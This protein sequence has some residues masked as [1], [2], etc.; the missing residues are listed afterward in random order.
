MPGFKTS[1]GHPVAY[2]DLLRDIGRTPWTS[3]SEQEFLALDKKVLTRMLVHP[4][5]D[6]DDRVVWDGPRQL[7][8]IRMHY[9]LNG[10]PPQ[11]LT[12]IGR[13]MGLSATTL[14]KVLER[15]LERLRGASQMAFQ[16]RAGAQ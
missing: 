14:R 16:G 5:Y 15:A 6:Y 12:A 9:G 8:V 2:H 11:G 4:D 10:M 1:R 13:E 7:Q 3:I